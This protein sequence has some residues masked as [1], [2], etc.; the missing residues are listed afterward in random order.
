MPIQSLQCRFLYCIMWINIFCVC[1]QPPLEFVL[2]TIWWK[3]WYDVSCL[4]FYSEV[5]G[6]W[7][8]IYCIV[9]NLCEC[10]QI[11][12]GYYTVY[13]SVLYY[14]MNPYYNT[15]SRVRQRRTQRNGLKHS[16]KSS[17]V[18][19]VTLRYANIFTHWTTGAELEIRIRNWSAIQ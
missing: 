8:V 9:K 12:P 3:V 11:I 13:C 7:L 18:A 2:I 6:H 1:V 10:H 16:S 19:G 14:Q 15:C 5:A 4:G 17:L